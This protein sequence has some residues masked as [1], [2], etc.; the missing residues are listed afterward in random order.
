MIGESG[1]PGPAVSG[2][3]AASSAT[4]LPPSLAD[5]SRRDALAAEAARKA[6]EE[7]ARADGAQPR[8]APDATAG[9]PAG[10]GA[11][12][13]ARRLRAPLRRAM[14]LAA[15]LLGAGVLAWPAFLNGYPL[16]FIDSVSYLGQ[17]LFPEWPWDKTPAYGPFLH[18][19]HWG[20]SLWPALAGQVLVVSHLLWLAQRAARGGISPVAHVALCAGLAGLTSLPWF[21]A[22]LMPDV[23]AAVAPL[24]L[25][26]LGLARE[27]LAR[28]EAWWLTLLGAF[29]VA[30]HLSHLP[31]ALALVVFVAVASRSMVAPLRAALPVA[32]AA[33]ALVA[34]NA[35]AFGK[36]TLSPHGAVFLLARLQA[37]GPAA[38]TIRAACPR[39]G[40]HLCGFAARL[41][42]DSDHFL[43][44]AEGPP[45][46]QP[47]GTPIPMGGMRIAPEAAEIVMR[48]LR[49][50]PA[51]VVAAMAHNTV[52]QAGMVAVGDTLGNR[53]LA[54]SA[55]RAIATLPAGELAAFDAGAQARGELPALAE[56]F[57]QPHR[58]ALLASLVLALAGL[59]LAL[60]RGDR[61]RVALV[62][63]LLVA[64]AVNAFATG[65]LSA[66]V[67]RYGA[68]IIW[69]LPLAAALALAP[70]YAAALTDAERV[71][72][73]MSALRP[74]PA[75]PED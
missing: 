34:A 73:R 51:E 46:R 64:V 67:D 33:G 66:P 22:T 23:F 17:T 38:R 74:P 62:V 59:L 63:G 21:A 6:A 30:T 31:T 56:P 60:W 20:W 42:M 44:S 35:W 24:C 26:L 70:R 9:A 45:N 72:A 49:E 11:A 53:H 39:A 65:A 58:P 29:A 40:W 2:R 55:R 47:N 8:A 48:T 75:T 4:G 18:A 61:V 68:R 19:F 32:I 69:L 43:W 71:R 54:A 5:L 36:P 15:I 12:V 41:P 27:R 25:L 1:R 16:V 50:R 7:R 14:S 57:L 28:R 13:S 10:G 37:D 52:A 3:R